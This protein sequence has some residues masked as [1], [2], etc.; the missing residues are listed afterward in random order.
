MKSIKAHETVSGL[1]LS[2]NPLSNVLHLS[3]FCMFNTILS[4]LCTPSSDGEKVIL[5]RSVTKPSYWSFWKNKWLMWEECLL[6]S[7]YF[8]MNCSLFHSM[9]FYCFIKC[10]IIFFFKVLSLPVPLL[11]SII[12]SLRQISPAIFTAFSLSLSFV[13]VLAPLCCYMNCTEMKIKSY[14]VC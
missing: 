8:L 2:T 6:R 12:F 10:F 7:K 14:S 3:D 13:A 11:S 9:E 4:V 5:T 1:A